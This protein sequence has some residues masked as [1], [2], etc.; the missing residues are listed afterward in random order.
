MYGQN[1]PSTKRKAYGRQC[2]TLLEVTFRA[3][4]RGG[5]WVGKGWAK[6]WF[7]LA[8]LCRRSASA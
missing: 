2:L 4:G 7:C 8:D 3:I 1:K 6:S 5:A